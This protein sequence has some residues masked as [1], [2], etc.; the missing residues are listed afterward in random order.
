MHSRVGSW[1][2]QIVIEE[3]AKKGII[4][5]KDGKGLSKQD[6]LNLYNMLNQ[7]HQEKQ[8]STNY[9][10]MEVGDEFN[11]SAED[12]KKM[13]EAAGYEITEKQ[14]EKTVPEDISQDTP[15]KPKQEEKKQPEEHNLDPAPKNNRAKVV[16]GK[17]IEREVNG[18]KSEIAIIKGS[19]GEK[20]RYQVNDDGTLGE[21]LVTVSTVG[22]NK[23]ITQSEMNKLISAQFPDGLPD[24]VTASCSLKDGKPTLEFK[25]DGKNIDVSQLK[26]VDTPTVK[27][28]GNRT[29]K[30][31]QQQEKIEI[32]P[33]IRERMRNVYADVQGLEYSITPDG[34]K[35]SGSYSPIGAAGTNKDELVNMASNFKK[36]YN[37][38]T[39]R[40]TKFGESHYNLSILEAD[41]AA[42][43]KKL[44][45]YQ[46]IYKDLSAKDPSEL[47]TYETKFMEK[48]EQDMVRFF[49]EYDKS[50]A[51]K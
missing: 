47:T 32:T 48:H 16:V 22:K 24:G 41:V 35:L 51:D 26:K 34:I 2:T 39:L 21:E 9:G 13:A 25:K 36:Y 23:Y 6:A 42:Q 14:H 17:V 7:I 43:A 3:L 20:I 4:K 29:I 38:K 15:V 33:K 50:V 5:D 8:L 30:K 49:Q 11:Y 27:N 37:P 10:S 31:A 45:I 40:Y 18:Q 19:D 44:A 12:L 46:A 1:Q 28:R